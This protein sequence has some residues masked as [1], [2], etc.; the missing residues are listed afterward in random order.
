M[1][2]C[3]YEPNASIMKAGCFAELSQHFGIAPIAT[4]SHL[5]VSA[6]MVNDFPGRTFQID[7]VTSLNKRELK[8]KTGGL[9][10]ANI[11]VRN[12]PLTVAEL[13]KRLKLSEGGST[14]IFATTLANGEKVLLICSKKATP[15]QQRR[16]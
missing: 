6:D 14:Y 12:F 9:T 16:A 4:N 11:T 10:Q 8:E 15:P 7:A 1:V 13:R 2:I 5:F 3:L